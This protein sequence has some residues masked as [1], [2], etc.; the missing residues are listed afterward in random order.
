MNQHLLT[1]Q[2]PAPLEQWYHYV[3]SVYRVLGEFIRVRNVRTDAEPLSA[4][5]VFP[6]GSV[7]VHNLSESCCCTALLSRCPSWQSSSWQRFAPVCVLSGFLCRWV[8]LGK[9]LRFFKI[10]FSFC[11]VCSCHV[12]TFNRAPDLRTSL[13]RLMPNAYQRH[14][15]WYFMHYRG[16]KPPL[17]LNHLQRAL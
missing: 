8:W 11:S 13:L 12:L 10:L 16:C 14:P 6:P 3:R 1:N 7:L 2:N 4:E 17:F 15:S 9:C 5:K